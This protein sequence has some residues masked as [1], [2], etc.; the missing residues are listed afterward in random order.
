[1]HISTLLILR[2]NPLCKI[3]NTYSNRKGISASLPP[4]AKGIS[5]SLPPMGK[6]MEWNQWNENLVRFWPIQ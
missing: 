3:K 6:G 4:M 2:K 1:M 5:A